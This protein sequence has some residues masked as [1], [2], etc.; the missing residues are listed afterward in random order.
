MGMGHAE[1]DP[2]PLVERK[3]AKIWGRRPWADKEGKEILNDLSHQVLLNEPDHVEDPTDPALG[4]LLKTHYGIDPKSSTLTALLSEGLTFQEAVV[5]Y[6][7][8]HCQLSVMDIF[9]ATSPVDTGGGVKDRA[10]ATRNI[11]RVIHQA[12]EKLGEDPDVPLPEENDDT[13]H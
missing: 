10:N 12:A 11:R 6:F 2:R 1:E 5:W 7:F 4:E 3:K 8:R 13:T 9:Y